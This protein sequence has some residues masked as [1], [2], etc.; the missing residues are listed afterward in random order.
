MESPLHRA[1]TRVWRMT[2]SKVMRSPGMWLTLVILMAAAFAPVLAPYSP[3]HQFSH[4]LTSSGMPLG[5]TPRFPLG[6]DAIGRDFLSRL[7]WG[8]RET[9]MISVPGGLLAIIIGTMVGVTAGYVGGLTDTALMRLTEVVLTIPPI[10]MAG[11]LSVLLH[12]NTL[13]LILILGLVMW[14]VPAR[15]VRTEVVLQRELA[16]VEAARAVGASDARIMMV[17]VLPQIGGLLAV[18]MSTQIA[19]I[20]TLTAGLS[21]VGIGIQPPTPSLGNLVASGSQWLG[22]A[23]RL[24]LWPGLVLGI[25]VLAFTLLGEDVRRWLKSATEIPL[26]GGSGV[27]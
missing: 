24:A 15:V 27:Q 1:P 4:G 7:L 2:R 14:Y 11:L 12:P 5:S 6:T 21:F 25:V 17:H 20:T 18:Y 3:Y 10:L 8:M 22:T 13:D 19:S 26:P 23:P 16:Y 9:L